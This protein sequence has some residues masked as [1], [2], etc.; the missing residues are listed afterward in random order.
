MGDAFSIFIRRPWNG[1]GTTVCQSRDGVRGVH[2]VAG[3]PSASD[4]VSSGA[5]SRRVSPRRGNVNR[6]R[7]LRRVPLRRVPFPF[8]NFNDRIII[9]IIK[10]CT[11][12]LGRAALF[13]CPYVRQF[14]VLFLAATDCFCI[15]PINP[16]NAK[17]VGTQFNRKIFFIHLFHWRE[18]LQISIPMN[19]RCFPRRDW[20]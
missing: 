6:R 17:P 8:P 7:F 16:A 3:V 14:R 2:F 19:G 9:I 15:L 5:D 18:A 1:V 10:R 4:A 12:L 13:F 20:N 11:W